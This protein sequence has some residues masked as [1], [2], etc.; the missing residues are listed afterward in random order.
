MRSRVLLLLATLSVVP[1]GGEDAAIRRPSYFEP[2]VRLSG[3]GVDRERLS[4]LVLA[5]RAEAMIESQTFSILREPESVAG[6]KRVA[7]PGLQAIFRKASA[8]SGLP[9]SL[10]EAM[11]YLESWGNPRA[12]SPTGPKGI[13]QIARATA[14]SMGLR[15]TYARRYR[16]TTQRVRVRTRSGKYVYQTVRRRTPYTVLVRD[17]RLDPALAIPAAAKYLARLEERYGGRDWAVFAYHCGESCGAEML[18]LTRKAKGASE[19]PTVAE[20]FFLGSPTHNR[21][22]YNAVRRHMDRDYSP[23]YWFRVMKAQ[24]LLRFWRE[25]PDGFLALAQYHRSDFVEERDKRAPHRLAVWLKNGDLVYRTREDILSCRRLVR[26]F[27]APDYLGY[28]LRMKGPGAIGALDPDNLEHYLRASPAAL[29]ALTYIAYETRRLHAALSPPGEQFQP[30]EVVSLVKPMEYRDKLG[31]GGDQAE[32]LA[33]CSGEVFDIDTS[34]LS[35]RQKEALEFVLDD[36]GWHNHLGFIEEA[37]RSGRLHIGPS[38]ASR[39][40]FARVYDESAGE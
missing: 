29:G 11:A 22:L 34:G 7:A 36:L 38:P 26:A 1:G 35:R 18:S 3:I 20:M 24:E 17:D 6:A 40:F 27:D 21:E 14:R 5:A 31:G 23:T 12:A 25:D 32:F 33:H 4:A 13:M 28:R 10:L 2:S 16:M 15:V 37:P 39:G 8:E 19:Q 30:L 9:A